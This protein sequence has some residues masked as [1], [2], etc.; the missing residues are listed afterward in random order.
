MALESLRDVF[1]PYQFAEALR[2]VT[3]HHNV[4]RRGLKGGIRLW[5]GQSVSPPG[6]DSPFSWEA[7]P[8]PDEKPAAPGT[9]CLWLLRFRPDQVDRA[10]LRG[11][12]IGDRRKIQNNSRD[13]HAIVKRVWRLQQIIQA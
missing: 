10:P 9:N 8:V 4:R 11:L 3:A 13:W 5:H 1:L 12:L 7:L 6:K 2:P